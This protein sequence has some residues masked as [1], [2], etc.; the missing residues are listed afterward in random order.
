MRP[1][2]DSLGERSRY[3]NT[4]K[5]IFEGEKWCVKRTEKTNLEKP[6]TSPKIG[7]QILKLAVV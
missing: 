3:G 2:P 4:C 6:E 5:S 7:P 1:S